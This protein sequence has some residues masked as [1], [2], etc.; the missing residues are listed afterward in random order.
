MLARSRGSTPASVEPDAAPSAPG[1]AVEGRRRGQTVHHLYP[2][3][4][5]LPVD[6]G[7]VSSALVGG[8]VAVLR[9]FATLPTGA[10]AVALVVPVLFMTTLRGTW[11]LV[12][13]ALLA[14]LGAEALA[15][16]LAPAPLA[17]AA[18][19]LLLAGWAVTLLLTRDVAWS[20]EALGG[21]VG[22]ATAAG[23]LAGWLVGAGSRVR[24]G[25]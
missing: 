2:V 18:C 10:V 4:G 5:Y 24:P 16:R 1:A 19:A 7:A 14:G 20:L 8:S 21:A 15:R 23:Y 13:A 22:S 17:A 6:G 11:T 25:A 9:T 12:P 3:T